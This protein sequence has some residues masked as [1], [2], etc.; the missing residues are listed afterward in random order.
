MPLLEHLA[1][2]KNRHPAARHHWQRR[3]TTALSQ[4]PVELRAILAEQTLPLQKIMGFKK[5]DIVPLPLQETV[6]V[7]AA[8]QP[9]FT[10]RVGIGSGHLALAFL[11]SLSAS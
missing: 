10:A 1:P 11:N 5:G 4:T 2:G 9:V 6:V 3:L 7:N 8:D